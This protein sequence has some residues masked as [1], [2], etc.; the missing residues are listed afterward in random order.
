MLNDF[1][2]VSVAANIKNR[3]KITLSHIHI[4][5]VCLIPTNLNKNAKIHKSKKCF[6]FIFRFCFIII[7]WFWCNLKYYNTIIQYITINWTGVFVYFDNLLTILYKYT[8]IYLNLH[9]KNLNM[10]ETNETAACYFFI[11]FLK[12]YLMFE[13]H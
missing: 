8:F 13:S 10:S 11:L 5:F 1:E 7:I 12:Y 9:L 4:Y 3:K 2:L 6:T